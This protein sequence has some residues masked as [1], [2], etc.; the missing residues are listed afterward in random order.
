VNRCL[1]IG[2]LAISALCAGKYAPASAAWWAMLAGAAGHTYGCNDVWQF[3]DPKR[4]PAILEAN[5]PWRKALEFPGAR[6]MGVLRRLLESRPWTRLAPDAAL[7]VE[8]QQPGQHPFTRL[9]RRMDA[10]P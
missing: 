6:Q 3:Y 10:R 1:W 8:G 9:A 7:I 4:A 5:T 2:S